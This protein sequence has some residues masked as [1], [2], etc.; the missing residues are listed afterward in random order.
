MNV[1]DLSTVDSVRLELELNENT[2]TVDTHF[3]LR[4]K[5]DSQSVTVIES[6][7]FVDSHELRKVIINSHF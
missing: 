7:W 1:K 2:G 3:P 5:S 6:I 4:E